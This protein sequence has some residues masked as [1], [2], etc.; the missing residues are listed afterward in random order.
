[1]KTTDGKAHPYGFGWGV[2]EVRG[3]KVIAH[4]GA[5]QGFESVISRYPDDK[6]TVIVLANL[7]EAKPQKIARGVAG[8][9]LPDLDAAK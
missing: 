2:G 1:V 9:Y 6:L 5:W 7:A 3:H 8:R 4:D